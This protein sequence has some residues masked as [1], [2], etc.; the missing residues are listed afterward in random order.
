MKRRKIGP[1]IIFLSL[2]VIT[3]AYSATLTWKLPGTR[4]DG[5]PLSKEESGQ[6]IMKVYSGPTKKG[7]WQW[8]ATSLPGNSSISVMDPPPGKTLWYTVKS[9]LNGAESSFATPVKKTN[10]LG[11][12]KR[13]IHS[14]KRAHIPHARKIAALSFLVLAVAFGWWIKRRIKKD[15]PKNSA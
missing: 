5:T 8:I 15:S 7:P 2:F 12:V 14:V 4:A 9:T 3:T 1:I 10:Y 6:I 11:L 13:L